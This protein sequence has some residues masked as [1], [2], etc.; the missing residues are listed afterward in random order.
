M[1]ALPQQKFFSG[2]QLGS[3]AFHQRLSILKE[4]TKTGMSQFAADI[5]V[6]FS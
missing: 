4:Q 1:A 2:C 6:K 3:F 5:P